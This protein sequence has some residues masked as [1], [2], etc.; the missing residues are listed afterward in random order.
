MISAEQ[1]SLERYRA[2][3]E[4]L[5]RV[6]VIGVPTVLGLIGGMSASA[7]WRAYMAWRNS[8]PFGIDDPQFGVDVSFFALRYPFWRF[9]LGYAIAVVIVCLLLAA[10]THYV[11]GGIR[12]QGAPPRV[13]RAA[14]IQLSIL[15]GIF[16]LLKA[17]GYW[18][19]RYSLAIKGDSL[20]DGFTGM[21]YHGRQRGAAR[22]GRSWRSS[23]W[24]ARCCSSP[25]LG[26]PAGCC[27]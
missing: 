16:M 2:G 25:T 11:F 26:A 27:R 22:Q 20:Y 18:L 14:H 4:G 13:S 8:S 21:R 1:V 6:I 23:P 17:V 19:D 24:S 12:L 10:V 3:M 7:H 9:M 5:H 15:A